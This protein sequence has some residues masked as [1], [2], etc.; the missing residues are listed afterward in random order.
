MNVQVGDIVECNCG[1]MLPIEERTILKIEG[2]RMWCEG[3][4]TMLLSDLR[5]P[6]VDYLSPIGVTLLRKD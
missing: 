2:D 5:D 3:G 4:F 6:D 1:I